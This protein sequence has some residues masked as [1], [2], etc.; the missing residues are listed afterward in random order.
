[1][2]NKKVHEDQKYIDGL[3]NNNSFIIQTIYDKF[4]PKVINYVKQNSGDEEYAQDVV[5]DTIITIYNQAIQKNLQLTCPFDAYFFLLCK[6]KWLNTLK[7][8]NNKEVT[9]NEEVLSKDD[10]AA[11]FVFET[12]IFE[13]KQ[14][15]FNQMF[16]QLGK[17]CKDLLNATF[18]IKSMEEVAASLNVSYAYAR[19][20][21]SLCIG[22]LTKMVQESPTFNQL[23]Y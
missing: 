17:A 7:K 13:N 18:K 10:D 3:V 19:K 20:K 6:R 23:N 21:K 9:I 16:D 4:V 22:Q 1:M 12:S 15:L 11:Q 14:N 2:S 8:I 5:Q